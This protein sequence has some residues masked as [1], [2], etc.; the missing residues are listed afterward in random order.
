ME[1]YIHTFKIQ[2]TADEFESK[3]QSQSFMAM[4]EFVSRFKSMFPN[5]NIVKAG[6]Y[7]EEISNGDSFLLQFI[8][9]IETDI[10]H[11]EVAEKQVELYSTN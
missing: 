3:F 1:N 2:L 6:G 11:L 9:E 10:T 4:G 7:M 8:I 5:A